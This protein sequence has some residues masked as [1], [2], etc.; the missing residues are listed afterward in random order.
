VTEFADLGVR[1][2]FSISTKN[3]MIHRARRRPN[4][5]FKLSR[6]GTSEWAIGCARDE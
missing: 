6:V 2:S 4:R 1:R 5:R 3:A